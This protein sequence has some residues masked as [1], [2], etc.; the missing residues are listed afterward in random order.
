[1]PAAEI[2]VDV[3]L[4]RRLLAEQFPELAPRPLTVL[5]NGWDNALFR[6]GED[7][8]VR[9]PRRRVAADLIGHEQR[10]LPALAAEQP[11]P[12]PVP[13]LVG[14]PSATFPWPWSITVFFTGLT[15]AAEPRPDLDHAA[16]ALGGFLARLHRPAPSDAP[17]NPVRGVPLQ[18]RTESLHANLALISEAIDTE[19]AEELWRVALAAEPWA[20]PPVW[21]HGDL[22]PANLL[23][24]DGALVA[25]LDF[26]DLTAG[27]PA[28]DLAVAWML[29][30]PAERATF[31]NSYAAAA[32]HPVG[33]ALRLRAHGWALH[34]GAVFVARSTDNPVMAA[35]G[36]ETVSAVLAEP[37]G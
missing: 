22:H 19:A 15:A 12:I 2:G 5:A 29:F 28:T 13:L 6:L 10:W 35:I 31:W 9:L 24:N 34:L 8:L 26:G 25:V 7:L 1:M 3:G 11:L 16:R 36:V 14:R 4:V 17:V 21:V 27:D 20:L 32:G 33:E 37:T 18:Q 30:P 23:T